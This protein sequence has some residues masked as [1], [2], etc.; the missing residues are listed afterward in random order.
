MIASVVSPTLSIRTPWQIP[1]STVEP[2]A[3]DLFLPTSEPSA[4]AK[5]HRALAGIALAIAVCGV[6]MGTLIN[7]AP[8]AL[9]SPTQVSTTR[10][11]LQKHVDYFDRNHDGQ[12]TPVETYQG[13]RALGLG[14]GRA[15]FSA[16]LINGTLGPKTTSS[17]TAPFTIDTARIHFAKHGSDTGI[18]DAQGHFVRAKFDAM[19]DRFDRDHDDAL[20][21]DEVTAMLTSNRTD[22]ASA[23]ASKGEFGLL[24]DVAG[25]DRVIDGHVTRVLTRE[26][27][28]ALYDGSLFYRISGEKVP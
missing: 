17:W 23:V 28:A 5:P 21:R 14:R 20:A 26:T 1:Q 8:V 13:L 22:G 2:P 6:G 7:V 24:L 25:E 16:A 11:T 15:T 4:E 27:M 18:I 3:A 10:T 19:F 12:I 9:P